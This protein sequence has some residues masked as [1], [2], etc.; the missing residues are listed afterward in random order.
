[1]VGSKAAMVVVDPDHHKA[2]VLKE[3]EL[4]SQFVSIGNYLAVEDTNING[5]PVAPS[6]GDGP[7]EAVDEFIKN[8]KDF[9]ID[10]SREKFLLTFFPEGFLKRI[11]ND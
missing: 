2:H 4:Y 3:M 6:C 8:R 10:R 1:M 5:H 9:E 11:E 7:M